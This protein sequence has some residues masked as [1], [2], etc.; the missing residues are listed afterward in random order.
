MPYTT[1]ALPDAAA[2]AAAAHTRPDRLGRPLNQRSLARSANFKPNQ[3]LLCAASSGRRRA[4][5]L[6]E[7]SRDWSVKLLLLLL[8]FNCCNPLGWESF[9]NLAYDKL[10][11]G[12]QL[13]PKSTD[14][15][16]AS[17]LLFSLPISLSLSLSCLLRLCLGQQQQQLRPTPTFSADLTKFSARHVQKLRSGGED[18]PTTWLRERERRREEEG[19]RQEQGGS[20]S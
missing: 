10:C 12:Q 9:I 1:Y 19:Q 14:N 8:G 4:G 13:E 17:A 5:R 3:L 11:L 20:P 6:V 15:C 2:A 7:G 18:R 16:A